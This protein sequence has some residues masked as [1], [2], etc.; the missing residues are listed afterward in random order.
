MQTAQLSKYTM[1]GGTNLS[2]LANMHNTSERDEHV[3]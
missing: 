1:G 3:T 2:L